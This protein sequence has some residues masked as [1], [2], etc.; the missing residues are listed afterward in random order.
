[1][2]IISGPVCRKEPEQLVYLHSS[3]CQIICATLF[4]PKSEK[5][6]LWTFA[7]SKD[8]GQSEHLQSLISPCKALWIIINPRFVQTDRKD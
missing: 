6:Y 1:M 4:E 8:S 5:M 2:F 7:L 3:V